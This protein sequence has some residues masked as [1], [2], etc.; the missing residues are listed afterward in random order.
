MKTKRMLLM[1]GAMAMIVLSAPRASAVVFPPLVVTDPGGTVRIQQGLPCG[2]DLDITR[3]I[4]SGRIEV[5]PLVIPGG[6]RAPQVMFNLMR[7]ELFLEPFSVQRKCRGIE[8]T[9]A[10]YEIGLRLAI[11]LVFPAEEVGPPGSGKFR[12]LIRKEEFLIY[13]TVFD[14]AP[15]PQPE[16]MYQRPSQDVTGMI[17]LGEGTFDIDIALAGQMR[18]RAGCVGN[19]C[20]I[21]EIKDGSQGANIRGAFVSPTR[22]QD[23][24]GVP[25]VVDNCPGTPNPSQAPDT[26]PPTVACAAVGRPGGAFQVSAVDAC[27]SRVNLRLGPF[28]LDNGEV[29]KITQTGQPGIRLL[30]G[31]GSGIRHFQVGR[32]QAIVGATDPAGNSASAAC[33]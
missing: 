32:D 10:F 25:D 15:F 13:E 18:F 21:D 1:V 6:D 26:T 12:F 20:L 28:T 11:G 27:S 29:I 8:A 14:N 33:R 5:T 2:D 9:A 19:A 30:P 16:R 3:R 7:L 23:G 17:D 4:T 31:D 24:D 22:D